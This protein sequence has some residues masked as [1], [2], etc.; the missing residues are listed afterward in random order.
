MIR[1]FFLSSDQLSDVRVSGRSQRLTSIRPRH[2]V[3]NRASSGQIWRSI[4]RRFVIFPRQQVLLIAES[5]LTRTFSCL[6]ACE[7]AWISI[8]R[9]IWVRWS[10]CSPGSPK[11][12][13]RTARSHWPALNWHYSNGTTTKRLRRLIK[14]ESIVFRDGLPGC[15]FQ[16]HSF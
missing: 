9:E 13:T 10:D 6:V 5:L 3:L 4:T 15:P 16:S 8:G 1:T 14:V 7:H 11:H 12:R 2:L